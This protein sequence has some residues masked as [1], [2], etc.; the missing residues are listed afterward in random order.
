M[1]GTTSTAASTAKKNRSPNATMSDESGMSNTTKAVRRPSKVPKYI[2][3]GFQRSAV[4]WISLPMLPSLTAWLPDSTGIVILAMTRMTAPPLG[5]AAPVRASPAPGPLECCPLADIDLEDLPG[6]A[7]LGRQFTL[8][9]TAWTG[10]RCG[11]NPL[12]SP[13]PALFWLD[14]RQRAIAAGWGDGRS[15]ISRLRKAL[16][17]HNEVE[18][19]VSGRVRGVTGACQG[20]R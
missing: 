13:G 20:R 4:V 11:I 12:R 2:A 14:G 5:A 17:W 7:Y 8:V 10:P 1:I 18:R 3:S 16:T 19:R 6:G 9:R 15:V